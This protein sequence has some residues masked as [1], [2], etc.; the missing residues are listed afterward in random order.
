MNTQQY[1]KALAKLDLPPHSERTALALGMSLSGIQKIA[2]EHVKV[3]GPVER[4]LAMY[5]R[6]GLPKEYRA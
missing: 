3:P 2:M 5:Q 1:L 4:L 6:H